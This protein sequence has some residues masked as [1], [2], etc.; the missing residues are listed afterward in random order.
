MPKKAPLFKSYIIP[1]LAEINCAIDG[2]T[3]VEDI[4]LIVIKDWI[5]EFASTH[6]DREE[7]CESINAF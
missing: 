1:L 3:I 7:V 6:E 2:L 5:R 4:R